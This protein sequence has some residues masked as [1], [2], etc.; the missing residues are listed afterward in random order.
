VLLII[1]TSIFA[2]RNAD[3]PDFEKNAD[4]K[5]KVTLY[6]GHS[7]YVGGTCNYPVLDTSGKRTG[8][9]IH[10]ASVE[11]AIKVFEEKGKELSQMDPDSERLIKIVADVHTITQQR[12]ATTATP[13]YEDVKMLVIDKLYQV[14]LTRIKAD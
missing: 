11:N 5:G 3:V 6:T 13:S 9:C 1:A 8:G 12:S 2:L 10:D 14:S 7:P 4:V